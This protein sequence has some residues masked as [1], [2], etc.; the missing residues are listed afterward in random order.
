[1]CCTP[2]IATLALCC[3]HYVYEATWIGSIAL[4]V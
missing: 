2:G 3:T 1:M 4:K